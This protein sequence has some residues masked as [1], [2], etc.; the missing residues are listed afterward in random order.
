MAAKIDAAAMVFSMKEPMMASPYD[1]RS[2]M[3]AFPKQAVWS[4]RVAVQPLTA[5]GSRPKDDI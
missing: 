5:G 3:I 1:G 4:R 2:G